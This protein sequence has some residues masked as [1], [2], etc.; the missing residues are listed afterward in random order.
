[1]I[2]YR[3][4]EEEAEA[5]LTQF[6]MTGEEDNTPQSG[7]TSLGRPSV[8]SEDH[9]VALYEGNLTHDIKGFTSQ[10]PLSSNSPVGH[11]TAAPFGPCLELRLTSNFCSLV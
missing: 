1:M 10:G 5:P 3:E 4:D 9:G 2:R 8:P 11:R 7:T 6:G